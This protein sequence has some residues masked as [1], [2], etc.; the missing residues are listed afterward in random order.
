MRSE[1][2]RRAELLARLVGSDVYN[3]FIC[4][5]CDGTLQQLTQDTVA[6]NIDLNVFAGDFPCCS[7]HHVG[8][9]CC[10]REKLRTPMLG[11]FAHYL[12]ASM[13]GRRATSCVVDMEVDKERFLPKTF[14]LLTRDDGMTTTRKTCELFGPLP[15]MLAKRIGA[16][17]MDIVESPVVMGRQHRSN[18]RVTE[19]G[20]LNSAC[21][22]I[23]LECQ[24]D[25]TSASTEDHEHF[26][27]EVALHPSDTNQP[28]AFW[29][30]TAPS[31]TQIGK[32]SRR[33]TEEDAW[34]SVCHVCLNSLL[35]CE[36]KPQN[37]SVDI[38]EIELSLSASNDVLGLK[39]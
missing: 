15:D 19:E 12:R 1:G 35:A 32:S 2:W 11:V 13:S 29:W 31:Q 33:V 27:L 7:V 34:T 3:V 9:E 6:H 17:Q 10:D 26:V 5:S 14:D 18:R 16:S 22:D 38:D 20:S 30:A 24:G 23:D 37:D 36:A 4:E 8:R 21:A 39:L 25:T 28:H